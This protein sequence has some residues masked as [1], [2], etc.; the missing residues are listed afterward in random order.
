[1]SRILEISYCHWIILSEIYSEMSHQICKGAKNLAQLL[2]MYQELAP[3]FKAQAEVL[4][5]VYMKQE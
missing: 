1:M 4:R 5:N 2:E 3:E